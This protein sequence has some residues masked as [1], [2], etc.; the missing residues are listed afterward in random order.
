MTTPEI[1]Y[2][3]KAVDPVE[4]IKSGWE[5]VKP[6]YWLF[7]GMTFVAFFIGSAVPF[8]I[9]MGPMMCGI[10]LTC[11]ARR[12]RE[13]VEFGLLFKGFDFFGPSVV[14]TLLHAVPIIA[15]LLPT[16]VLFYASFVLALVAQGNDPNP[17]PL[18]AVLGTFSLIVVVVVVL[19]IIVSIGF[20]FA[21]P[22]IVDRRLAGWDAVKLSFK[23]AM[24]NFWRLLAMNLLAGVMAT[25]GMAFC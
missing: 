2:N 7:V 5:L 24:A 3:R 15:I 14:A 25:V 16:Y 19:I 18:L 4:C 11:F 21:Y 23:A 12:R 8:G 10:Y 6:Q 22:L 17:M 9:L 13:P 1:P 20:T